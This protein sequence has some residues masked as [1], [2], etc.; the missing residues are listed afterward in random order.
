MNTFEKYPTRWRRF[1]QVGLVLVLG[2][3]GTSGSIALHVLRAESAKAS[4]I[5]LAGDL[6]WIAILLWGILF[7]QMMA[8]LNTKYRA[9]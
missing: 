3:L 5:I 4:V 6:L 1:V 8:F 9:A 7:V 2:C